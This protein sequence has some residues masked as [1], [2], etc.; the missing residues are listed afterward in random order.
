MYYFK[1]FEKMEFVVPAIAR[2]NGDSNTN[3]ESSFYVNIAT[4]SYC[5]HSREN[6][7][8]FSSSQNLRKRDLFLDPK[9]TW[10]DKPLKPYRFE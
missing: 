7:P 10:R 9:P 4:S 1:S 2:R 6:K 8:I 5:F 3:L